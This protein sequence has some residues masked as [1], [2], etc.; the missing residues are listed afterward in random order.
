MAVIGTPAGG[1]KEIL[2]DG[3][4]AL[5]S[6]PGDS[7][8]LAAAIYKLANDAELRKRLGK[9]AAQCVRENFDIEQTIE[10][11]EQYLLQVSTQS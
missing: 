2:V 1:S 7:E 10:Q 11:V 3:E 5:V 6:L 9:K 4:H 8:A